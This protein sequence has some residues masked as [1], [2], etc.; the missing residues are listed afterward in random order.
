MW[1][2]IKYMIL[3]LQS[4]QIFR[5]QVNHHKLNENSLSTRYQVPVMTWNLHKESTVYLSGISQENWC[6]LMYSGFRVFY[7]KNWRFG[8]VGKAGNEWGQLLPTILAWRTASGHLQHWLERCHDSYESFGSEEC[9]RIH[10]AH[11]TLT[12]N[13]FQ[14]TGLFSSTFQITFEGL[15]VERASV[16]GMY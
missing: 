15:S 6:H 14:R 16:D 2:L 8:T 9:M 12:G 10:C 11:L 4:Y 7:Y 5:C 1:I 13:C 3:V